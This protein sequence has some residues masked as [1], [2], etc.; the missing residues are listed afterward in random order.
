VDDA[1]RD[2]G[3]VR[4]YWSPTQTVTCHPAR[5]QIVMQSHEEPELVA[6]LPLE[7][8]AAAKF[9]VGGY[10]FNSLY[11]LPLSSSI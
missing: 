10:F 2:L 11:K 7:K 6:E 9:I 1:R 3:G 8:T 5:R 4:I